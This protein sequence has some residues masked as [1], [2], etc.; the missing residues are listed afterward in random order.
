MI[1]HLSK[2]PLL[3]QGFILKDGSSFSFNPF[4]FQIKAENFALSPQGQEQASLTLDNLTIDLSL[5]PLFSKV[6]TFDEISLSGLTTSISQVGE[7]ITI[8]GKTMPSSTSDANEQ[9]SVE[10]T[11]ATDWQ[12]I[13]PVA[14]FENINLNLLIDEKPLAIELQE[15]IVKNLIASPFTLSAET[16]IATLINKTAVTLSASLSK[17]KDN[18]NITLVTKV[19]AKD[20]STFSDFIT[21]YQMAGSLNLDLKADVDIE[22]S[23]ISIKSDNIG[24]LL[25]NIEVQDKEY[26]A[27]LAA[28]DFSLSSL[29]INKDGQNLSLLADSNL[30]IE[31]IVAAEQKSKQALTT[32]KTIKLEEMTTELANED[33][34]FAWHSL[35]VDDA[36]F[37]NSPQ[38]KAAPMA[39][40]TQLSIA[41]GAVEKNAINLGVINLSGL[42]GNLVI[43]ADKSIA[44]LPRT[45]S[46]HTAEATERKE[47]SEP[48]QRQFPSI[49]LA[50][51]TITDEASLKIM[52]KSVSPVYAEEV[53][54][55][56]LEVSEIDSSN[57]ELVSTVKAALS[58]DDYSTLSA[59]VDMTPFDEVP[60]YDVSANLKEMS[61]H[62]ISPYIQDAMQHS[63][64]S[65][66]LAIDIKT[67]IKGNK[68]DGSAD[69]HVAAFDLSSANDVEV[70]TLKDQTAIP[71]SAALGLLKDSDGNIEIDLPITGDI[72]D[73]SFGL[74]GF[75]TLLVK[76]A[77][78]MA[79]KDYLMTTFV[80]YANVVTIAMAAG[81]HLLK[82]RLNDLPYNP[83]ET[84]LADSQL[85]FASELIQ[86]LKDND[87]LRIT[88]CAIGVPEDVGLINGKKIEDKEVL[89]QLQ[90]L[91]NLRSKLFKQHLVSNGIA[92]DRIVQC[93]A[94]ID[95]SEK[96]K[97]RL[98]F[99][100]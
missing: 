92:S 100:T 64:K 9:P 55:K 90:V 77:T 43:E 49:K 42:A 99:A 4:I 34:K 12:V 11:S 21:P 96:A 73:P 2:Q 33:V 78:M 3:E 6:I 72:N 94:E 93:A 68:I 30:A 88:L 71:L 91:S 41:G 65:G 7:K 56:S 44:N 60:V 53:V 22:D 61:L 74:S 67:L 69:I 62:K 17:Q 98:T 46:N 59:N 31:N 86:L 37:L 13:T 35:V 58:F 84:S 14:S 47:T 28:L 10:E 54:L 5:W 32:L 20:I 8:A 24:L 19:D 23:L 82:V 80:P 51:F 87:D 75:A 95:F 40:F 26:L 89:S 18:T 36:S 97:P 27:N 16:S 63:I 66:Q 38:E 50:G 29:L 48:Q 57:P 52:D 81:E 15:I 76:K 70:D 25:K 83:K 85:L 1:K 45:E 79:A 39:N